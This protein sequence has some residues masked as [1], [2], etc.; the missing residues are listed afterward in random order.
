MRNI[1]EAELVVRNHGN[2]SERS[3]SESARATF[4]LATSAHDEALRM[5]Y[6]KHGRNQREIQNLV[7]GRWKHPP[8]Y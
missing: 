1:N 2:G 7:T 5:L 3:S 6:T 8:R 4:D